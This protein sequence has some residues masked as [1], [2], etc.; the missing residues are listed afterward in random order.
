MRYYR[1]LFLSLV[2]TVAVSQFAYADTSL[3]GDAKR[4]EAL[5]A[6]CAACHSSDGNSAVPNFLS[7]L[8]SAKNIFTS[9]YWISKKSVGLLLK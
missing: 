1:N 3:S 4:G 6:V 2:A 9:S 7:L 8:D 5:T